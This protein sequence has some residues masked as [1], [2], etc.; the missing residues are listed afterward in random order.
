MTGARLAREKKCKGC[1][2]AFRPW[3]STQKFCGRDCSREA[4]RGKPKISEAGRAKLQRRRGPANPAFKH[5]E[6]AGAGDRPGERRFV[7]THKGC[8]NPECRG[9]GNRHHQHHAVYRQQVRRHGGDEWD[10]RNALLLCDSCHLRHHNRCP[11]LPAT[12]LRSENI[13]FAVELL[14][15][16]AAYE[17]L[18]RRY[19]G[20][21]PRLEALIA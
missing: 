2:K 8:R 12:V 14:G 13:A 11:A 6:R 4:Q 9:T 16:P 21:D 17:Y 1:G 3:R 19:T 5:G 20:D 18:R 7:D 10:P 15:A